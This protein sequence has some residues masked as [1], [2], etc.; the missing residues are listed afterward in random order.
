[1]TQGELKAVQ[2]LVDVGVALNRGNVEG[3]TSLMQAAF[4]GHAAIIT[5]LVEAGADVNKKDLFG[6]D[7]L[8]HAAKG[9]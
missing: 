7:A 3:V 4:C 2:V 1:M 6:R 8:D 9:L 5:C